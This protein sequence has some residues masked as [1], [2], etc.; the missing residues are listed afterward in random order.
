M[1]VLVGLGLVPNAF[2]ETATDDQSAALGYLLLAAALAVWLAYTWVLGRTGTSVG[3]RVV[4]GKLVRGD[5]QALPGF[6]R[7]L[8][9]TSIVLLLILPLF[10]PLLIAYAVARTRPDRM[11][12]Q[13]LATGT[14][15]VRVPKKSE[16]HAGPRVDTPA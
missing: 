1:A 6:G 11:T 5:G 16:T 2:D 15:P 8:A 14:H 13:D 4:G 9:R 10:V 12:V 7:A 3:K